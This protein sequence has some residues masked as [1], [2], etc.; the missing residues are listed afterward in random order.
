MGNERKFCDTLRK[1]DTTFPLSV[2]N[3]ILNISNADVEYDIQY[4][5]YLYKSVLYIPSVFLNIVLNSITLC[6]E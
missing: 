1:L 6:F 4:T 5:H 3:I 2:K